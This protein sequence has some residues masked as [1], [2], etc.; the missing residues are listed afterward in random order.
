MEYK[1]P[2]IEVIYIKQPDIIRT[3]SPVAP[4]GQ[5]NDDDFSY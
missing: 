4:G 3:S 5:D 1:K 2:Y